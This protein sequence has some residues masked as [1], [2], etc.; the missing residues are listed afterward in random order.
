MFH[1]Y[2]FGYIFCHQS[3]TMKMFWFHIFLLCNLYFEFYWLS[4]VNI[5]HSTKYLYI[6]YN[7]LLQQH[8]Y[9]RLLIFCSL[10]ST[11]NEYIL[12]FNSTNSLLAMPAISSFILPMTICLNYHSIWLSRIITKIKFFFIIA[13]ISIGIFSFY[14]IH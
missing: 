14:F 10:L 1:I 8:F 2:W 13:K 4:V 11:K 3:K 6:H 5:Y 7:L 9:L 12:S